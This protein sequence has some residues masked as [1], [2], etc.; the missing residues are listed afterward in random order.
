MGRL[1][2]GGGGVFFY[3][4]W[5]P[6]GV[7]HQAFSAPLSYPNR[8][9]VQPENSFDDDCSRSWQTGMCRQGVCTIK[10]VLNVH[11]TPPLTLVAWADRCAPKLRK[12]KPPAPLAPSTPPPLLISH[13]GPPPALPPFSLPLTLPLPPTPKR[14]TDHTIPMP[15][16]SASAPSFTP[17]PRPPSHL[18]SPSPPFRVQS[19]NLFPL[20]PLL[21]CLARRT[22]HTLASFP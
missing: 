19:L 16:T 22:D 2:F 8:P 21:P 15:I 11:A 18:P 9:F 7:H 4:R 12:G 14:R 1:E 13:A 3:W 5:P 10:R 20:T 17:L 6:R